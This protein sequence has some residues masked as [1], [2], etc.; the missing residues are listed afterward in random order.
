MKTHNMTKIIRN[1]YGM[2]Y[3]LTSYEKHE[4]ELPHEG[5]VDRLN[6]VVEI[7]KTRWV[8][9][10]VFLSVIS[11]G[12]CA[13]YYYNE[14][15]INY[16]SVLA[17]KGR[18]ETLLQRR[19]DISINLSKAVYDYSRHEQGVFTA[20][21]ALR[22]LISD[23]EDNK[24]KADALMKKLS[25]PIG[26]SLAPAGKASVSEPGAGLHPSGVSLPLSRLLAVAEQYP[27]LKLSAAFQSLM[28]ALVEV[29]KDLAAE[30]IRYNDAVN[31]YTTE[32]AVFPAKVFAALY[33]FETTAYFEATTEAKAL[34]PI[35]Y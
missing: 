6:P 32:L 15:I 35:R 4:I 23:D 26:G 25:G 14:L 29:E 22:A 16:Q 34:V 7:V 21:V 27:D 28:G 20:I 1:I 31:I 11:T 10:V 9:L 33:G 30:R 2:R 17:A 5:F 18:V 19:N 8:L 3:D 13:V 24:G 12:A